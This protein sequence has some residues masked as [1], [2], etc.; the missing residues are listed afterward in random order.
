V[1]GR[2]G[3][4]AHGMLLVKGEADVRVVRLTEGRIETQGARVP[5]SRITRPNRYHRLR[6]RILGPCPL[7]PSRATRS[8]TG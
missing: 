2:I 4:R 8:R 7:R 6:R 3:V 5:P 1:G